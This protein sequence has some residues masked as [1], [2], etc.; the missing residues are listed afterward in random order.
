VLEKCWEVKKQ[1]VSYFL[2]SNYNFFL[3]LKL[4]WAMEEPTKSDVNSSLLKS[5]EQE[6]LK[7]KDIIEQLGITSS[8]MEPGLLGCHM[9]GNDV[10]FLVWAPHADKVDVLV[11]SGEEWDYQ[12]ENRRYPL[13]KAG[14]GYWEGG[15]SDI[16]P[17]EIYRYEITTS[18]VTFMTIDPL[19]RDTV[20]SWNYF[21]MEN[22]NNAAIIQPN[23]RFDWH[24]FNTPR[25][26]DF[27]IYQCHVG[28]FAG[29]NDEIENIPATFLDIIDKL[30][31]I[32][33]MDFTAIQLMPI[34]E[35]SADIS[36]GYNTA[37]YFAPESAYGSPEDLRNLVNEAHK[38][39]LAV[40]FDV[41]YNHTGPQDN[42]LWQFDG[43]AD[44]GGIYFEGG[45][46]TSWGRGPA[47]QK[48]DVQEF[49]FQNA[50]MYFDEYKADGLRFDCTTQI[51]GTYLAIVVKRLREKYPNKYLIAE[52]LP[53][54]PWIITNGNFCAT[55]ESEAHHECQRALVG[56]D[57]VNK[58]LSILGHD[59]FNHSWNLV[60]YLTGCHDDIGD[61]ENGDAEHGLGNWDARHRYLIDLL[62]GRYDWNARAKCRLA[63]ALNVSI[64]GNPHLFMGTECLMASPYV[65]WGYWHDSIDLNGD[66][67]FNWAIA[68]DRIGMEMR[69]LV[70]D[71]NAVRLANEALKQDHLQVTHIDHNHQIIAF[72][73]WDHNG[74]IVL[75]VVNLGDRSFE[76]HSYGVN[77][78]QDG[79]WE[80]ALC[81]QDFRY[82]GWD[83]SGNAYYHPTTM[84]DGR[85]YLNVPKLSVVMMKWMGW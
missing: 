45:Q 57:S 23:I 65:G 73:R 85:I 41:V 39:G 54:H 16:I 40:I 22:N 77:T 72:K 47:W 1:P 13:L 20:H 74:N 56:H 27:I 62:G 7:F 2:K 18:G 35:F 3:S 29:R 33:S 26:H 69:N 60:K 61:F 17:Y 79:L 48:P 44:N 52:H 80:Q 9:I 49:F 84:P 11:Q 68:G 55:C 43:Y 64:S 10:F 46:M 25:F 78:G 37:L 31:Y 30:D 59:R 50:C 34:A 70:S 63:Y 67:R 19:A 4:F 66:H 32:K 71:S 5:D 15:F 81:S 38:R 36:W 21:G 82:G 24:E 12:V 76:N 75:V 58:I 14:E 28:T 83:G 42:S 51:N 6:E 8:L 53:A